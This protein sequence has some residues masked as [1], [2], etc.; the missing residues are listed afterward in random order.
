MAEPARVIL[1]MSVQL[2]DGRKGAIHV[3]P[4]S[5]PAE[6]AQQFCKKHGLSDP[7]L[8]RVV[9]RHI[10]DNI[11]NLPEQKPRRVQSGGRPAGRSDHG[12][13]RAPQGANGAAP[14]PLGPHGGGDEVTTE[15]LVTA[16]E[17]AQQRVA[18]LEEREGELEA[19]LEAAED[20]EAAQ[21]KEM[22]ELHQ[23]NA[24]IATLAFQQAGR[25]TDEAAAELR[26]LLDPPGSALKLLNERYMLVLALLGDRSAAIR[27]RAAVADAMAHWGRAQLRRREVAS[28]RAKAL[29][30]AP[31]PA[32]G[33]TR[34]DVAVQCRIDATEHGRAGDAMAAEVAAAREKRLAAE[35]Q[36]DE[37]R[38][39]LQSVTD[40]L[41]DVTKALILAK[42]NQ[43]ELNHEKLGLDHEIKQLERQIVVES[44]EQYDVRP[45]RYPPI[46]PRDLRCDPHVM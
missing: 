19:R 16:L 38:R 12:G 8:L 9:E 34:F 23:A 27:Q 14:S 18:E 43:A 35:R 5:D 39:Q 17:A 11:R 42:I 6:L 20:R 33:P 31:P 15:A 30:L 36:A 25:S 22:D 46:P 28:G 10:V 21:A 4:G 44:V 13:A 37:L 32:L 24:R 1:K 2:P 3:F 41:N 26:S 40:E 29:G 7:K 45:P